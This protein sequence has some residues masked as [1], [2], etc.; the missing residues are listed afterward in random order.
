RLATSIY[1]V[2]FHHPVAVAEQIGQLDQISG[3]RVIFGVGIGYRAYEF[4][5]YGTDRKDR[6]GRTV[7]SIRAIRE[8]WNRGYFEFSGKHFQIP[9]SVVD[10][11][12][13]Q[14]PHPPMWMGGAAEPAVQR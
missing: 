10:P 1:N 3:G 5:A 7:E 4:A 14:S 2:S 9:H 13:I 8:A 11:V 12:P 6:V